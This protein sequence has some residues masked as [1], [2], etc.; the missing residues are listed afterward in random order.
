MAGSMVKSSVDK[1]AFSRVELMENRMAESTAAMKGDESAAK[2]AEL[3]I[4]TMALQT[5]VAMVSY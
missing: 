2:R 4:E 5:V 1:R 3:M